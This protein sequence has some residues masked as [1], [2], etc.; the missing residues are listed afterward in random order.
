MNARTSKIALKCLIAGGVLALAAGCA[1]TKQLEEVRAEA[2]AA[3]QMASEAQSMVANVRGMVEDALEQARAAQAA[4]DASQN[5]CNDLERKL[6]RA[7]QE[8]QEK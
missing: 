6:D 3:R 2:E 4:A 7:L 5:C 1:S 8:M